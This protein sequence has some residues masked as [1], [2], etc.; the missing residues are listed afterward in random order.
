MKRFLQ[1][2]AALGVMLGA[3]W[4]QAALFDVRIDDLTETVTATV[5]GNPVTLLPDSSGEFIHFTI[6]FSQP[7]TTSGT[8]SIDLLEPVSLLLSDRLLQT[9]TNHV[10]IQFSSDPATFPPPGV[11][12][13]APLVE[14]GTFQFLFT[15]TVNFPGG[16]RD[17][18]FYRVRSD[19]VE[20][21]PEPSTYLLFAAGLL[22]LLAYDGR[23][24]AGGVRRT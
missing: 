24:K 13:F 2:F 19:S 9:L 14:D 20:A 8:V 11:F 3:G 21:V 17:S 23:R 5:N 4:A 22:A 6:P 7:L 12:T 15:T 18:F 16:G 1:L 10:D